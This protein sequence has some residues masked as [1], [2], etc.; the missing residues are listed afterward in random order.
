MMNCAIIN[1]AIMNSA[2]MNSAIIK[3]VLSPKYKASD[4]M[5]KFPTFVLQKD[6]LFKQSIFCSLFDALMTFKPVFH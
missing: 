3:P 1:S 6:F 4:G 5:R 2:I